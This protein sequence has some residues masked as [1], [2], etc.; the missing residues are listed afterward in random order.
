M[1][2]LGIDV[3]TTGC[4]AAAFALDG[5]CIAWAYREYGTLRPRPG[6]AELDSREVWRAVR[7]VIAEVASRAN[8]TDPVA[9]L[10]VSSLGE[11][12]VPVTRDREILGNSILCSDSRGADYAE[13]LVDRFGAED[14]YRINPN[15]PGPQY[16]LPKM[17]WIRD[18]EPDVFRKTDY[19][20]LWADAV[21]F[22]LGC[23]PVSANSLANRTLLLD[24][25]RNDWSDPLLEWSGIDRGKLGRVAAAGTILG[26]VDSATAAALALPP[27]VQVV[28]GG[29][30]Q[31][32][33]ALGCGCV[34]AG[35][36]ACGIGTFECIT[37]VYPRPANLLD[38]RT[39]G[40]NIEHHVIPELFVSF[41]FNQA[42]TLVK[43]FRE[44][45]AK[46]DRVPDGDDIH[47]LLNREMPGEPTNLLVLPHFETPVSPRLIA[48]SSGAIVGLRASTTRGEI[49]KA[50]LECETLYFV[51][52]VDALKRLG[53]DTREFVVSGGGAKS[54]AWLQ[55]KAD[56]FG[57]PY[58]RPRIAE[59]SAL[60]AA[61]IAGLATGA[62]ASPREASDCFVHMDRIFEPDARRHARY[63][64]KLELYRRL[65]PALREISAGLGGRAN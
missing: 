33:N 3:G 21:V 31:C 55:I 16:S 26:V 40:L 50:I 20:L 56:I 39:L 10:S 12:F 6:W 53:A 24:L 58:L 15:L 46:A 60:G 57:V 9:A 22:L 23:D 17:M 45:F 32:C 59:A 43:W 25:D 34:E 64:E 35:R 13:A 38:V 27:G 18:H 54:D 62:F 37:P 49:L 65:Y 7:H 14:L 36:A 4:K 47:A 61:M 42:G 2:L 29:H 30:D 11:A 51:D 5:Q 44:T 63:R 52:S 28:V 41:V 8:S 19:F 1:S 48:D